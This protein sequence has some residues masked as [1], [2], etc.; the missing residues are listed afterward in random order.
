[1]FKRVV[2]AATMLAAAVAQA[3]TFD[4]SYVFGS[5]GRTVSGSFDGTLSGDLVTGLSNISV[6]Y[7]GLAFSGNGSLFG[8][9]RNSAN[10]GWVS[11]GAVVSFSG[12]A[13]NF[14]F[15]DA[16]VP[17][18]SS[19]SNYFYSIPYPY[20]NPLYAGQT[21]N[22]AANIKGYSVELVS[23]GSWS[24]TNVTAVPEP[25]TYAMMLAGLGV[26]GAFARR[27]KAKQTA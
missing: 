7:D 5:D 25:E 23:S 4:F 20:P 14:L 9:S 1:M 12:T 2:I 8:S 21:V 6:T 19:Y 17:N 15:S 18:S 11:G 27:R 16:D 13:N 10:T 24:L 26:M 3:D 22:E